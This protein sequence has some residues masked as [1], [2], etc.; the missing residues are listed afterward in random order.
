MTTFG[1]FNP[2]L[3]QMISN[4]F[5][6]IAHPTSHFPHLQLLHAFIVSIYVHVHNNPLEPYHRRSK[7]KRDHNIRPEN[8]VFAGIGSERD[9]GGDYQII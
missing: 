7:R 2:L 6:A 4:N 9:K 5:L 8:D 3:H 1:T